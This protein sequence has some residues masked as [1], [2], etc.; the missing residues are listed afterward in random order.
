MMV[1]NIWSNAFLL[2]LCNMCGDGKFRCVISSSLLWPRFQL[3]C[4]NWFLSGL[5]K[6]IQLY[7]FSN[8]LWVGDIF[9]K[10]KKNKNGSFLAQVYLFP[11]ILYRNTKKFSGSFSAQVFCFGSIH[12][13][14]MCS[15]AHSCRK[16]FFFNYV[17][18]FCLTKMKP[19]QNMVRL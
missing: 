2:L 19:N 18:N 9:F 12:A 8:I 17:V 16:P 1:E 14:Y 5:C 4:Y 6:I 15:F 3:I 10:R 11:W 7:I 13:Y